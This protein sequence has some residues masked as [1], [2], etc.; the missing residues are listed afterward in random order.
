MK[1]VVIILDGAAGYPLPDYGD[2]TTLELAQT[3]HLDQMAAEGEL[4]LVRTVPEGMEP[5]SACACLSLL[6]YDPLVYYSG[7]AGIEAVGM[8]LDVKED[9]V[10]FRANLVTILE[11]RMRSHSGGYIAS[12]EVRGLIS[13]LNEHLGRDAILYPGEGYRNLLKL[14]GHPETLRAECTPPHDIPDQ[15]VEKYLPHGEGSEV[16]RNIMRQAA[17]VLA[18]HPINE[19]RIR[20]GE[21]PANNIWLFWGSRGMPPLPSFRQS[22]GLKAALTSGVDLLRGL[23][24]V[25]GVKVLTIPG[26][27]GDL[28]N[29]YAA[30]VQGTISALGDYELVVVHI[31]APDEAGH[32]GDVEAKVT[33]IED[34]DRVVIADLLELKEPLRI[35]VAVDHP[36]PVM[37]RTHVARPVPFLL[38][39]PGFRGQRGV[40]FCERH[41]E[42]A[43]LFIS[44]GYKLMSRF[45]GRGE[46]G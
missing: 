32:S 41:A 10:V 45:I 5:S 29:D 37:V 34:A 24:R 16:L 18:P 7:R 13:S 40:R 36:T 3:P 11:G 22:F 42:E 33:A 15:P 19:A 27:R 21:L 25:M 44:P 17:T 26:V 20:R 43:S 1:Y 46:E 2:R 31:E 9:E 28:E 23:G 8:G 6:G 14:K 35:M 12:K 4:G 38:W 39:G 30:Q